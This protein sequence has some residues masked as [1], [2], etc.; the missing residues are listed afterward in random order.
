MCVNMYYSFF[1]HSSVDGHLGYFYVLVI[2]NSATMNIGVCVSVWIRTLFSLDICPGLGLLDHMVT[3][4]LVFE[5]TSILFPM[6]AAPIY[7]PTNGVRGC[8]FM[9]ICIVNG[10]IN[11]IPI[12][13]ALTMLWY[14]ASYFKYYCICYYK[15]MR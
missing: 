10:I 8:P 1:I 12:N 4:S 14:H 2:I 3:L 11:M 9:N 6:V 7:I 5:G 15:C 13:W